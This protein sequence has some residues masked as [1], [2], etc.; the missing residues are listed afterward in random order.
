MH[1]FLSINGLFKIKGCSILGPGSRLQRAMKKNKIQKKNLGFF[2]AQGDLQSVNGTAVLLI[3]NSPY[4]RE[5][6]G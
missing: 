3:R 6:K 2:G 1:R 4:F 5:K